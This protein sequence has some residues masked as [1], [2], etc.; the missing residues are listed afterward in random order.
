MVDLFGEYLAMLAN[1]C[2]E[3]LVQM[4]DS[5]SIDFPLATCI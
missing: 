3:Y 1:C 2:D 5:P 4:S